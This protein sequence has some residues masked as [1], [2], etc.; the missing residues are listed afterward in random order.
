MDTVLSVVPTVFGDSRVEG[1]RK[2]IVSPFVSTYE[3]PEYAV[4][5]ERYSCKRAAKKCANLPAEVLCPQLTRC[6]I[7]L[8]RWG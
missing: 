7:R 8:E 4:I 2:G 5:A 6:K 1:D 3:A